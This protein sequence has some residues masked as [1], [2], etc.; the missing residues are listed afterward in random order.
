MKYIVAEYEVVAVEAED[1]ILASGS[2]D[3]TIGDNDDV[4]FPED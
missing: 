4:T 1:V 3:P 2:G